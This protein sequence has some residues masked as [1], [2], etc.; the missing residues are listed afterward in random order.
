MV[1]R[2]RKW[3]VT[4]GLLL[5]AA[6]GLPAT[7][8]DY[9]KA[10]GI[11]PV[12]PGQDYRPAPEVV[13]LPAQAEPNAPAPA[14]PETPPPPAAECPSP[15]YDHGRAG[16]WRRHHGHGDHQRY[17]EL[18]LGTF[19]YAHGRTMVANG[20]A[21]RM[22][23]HDYDFVEGASRLHARGQEQLARIAALLPANFFPI[24][25]ERGPG[26]SDLDEAR[27]MA[28]LTELASGPFPVP[29]ERIVIGTSPSRGLR[30]EEIEIIYRNLL[31]QTQTRGT[32]GGLGSDFSGTTGSGAVPLGSGVSPSA[33]APF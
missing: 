13:A 7:A 12:A 24:V 20:E 31:I 10:S 18:P 19:L 32:I 5:S 6:T 27:R 3:A 23:L 9:G 22:V 17:E 11:G 25:I 26:G 4:T 16:R 33:G 2:R 1:L 28:V 15:G 21:A 14:G 8:Q 30:G 29:A